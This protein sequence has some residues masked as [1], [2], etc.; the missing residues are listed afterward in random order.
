MKSKK[1][2]EDLTNENAT[3]PSIEFRMQTARLLVELKEFKKCVKILDMIIKEEDERVETWY[4]LGLS[5][6]NLNLFKNA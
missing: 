4:L 2:S 3:L 1:A 6:Y 5:L